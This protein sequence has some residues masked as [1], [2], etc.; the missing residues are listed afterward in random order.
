M[1]SKLLLIGAILLASQAHAA[2]INIGGQCTLVRAINAANNDRTARGRCTQ[3]NG[4]D[5]VVLPAS[6]LFLLKTVNNNALGPG[7]CLSFARL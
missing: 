2:V 5:M 6:T 4:A 7:G 3:G 1:K